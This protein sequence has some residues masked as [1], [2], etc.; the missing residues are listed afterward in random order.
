MSGAEYKI[1]NA[2][3]RYPANPVQAITTPPG[4]GK[5]IDVLTYTNTPIPPK[6]EQ[7]RFW[8]ELNKRVGSPVTVSLTPSVDYTQKFATAVAGDR[9]GDIFLVG[10]V[11]QVPQLLEAEGAS[12]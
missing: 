7:N 3:N 8:Q 10:G 6:L 9:L 1:P 4:D 12:T 2:F 11:P 5:P